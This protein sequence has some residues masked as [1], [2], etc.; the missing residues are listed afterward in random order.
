[1]SWD[2]LEGCALRRLPELPDE[3]VQCVVTSPPYWGLRDYG[4]DGQIGLEETPA[5]WLDRMVAVFHEVLRVLRADGTCWVNVG[6]SYATGTTSDRGPTHTGTHGYWENPQVNKRINGREYGLK[7]KDLV[8]IPW[9]L[10]F[11]LRADG[12]Y[13]RQDIIWAKP[14]P[15][16]ESA[17]DRCTK[18]HEY[19]FLLTKSGRYYYDFDAMQEPVTGNAHSRGNG[20]NP[21]AYKMPDGW[22]SSSGNGGHGSIH[23]QGREKGKTPQ[24]KQNES[25]SAAVTDPVASRNR[26]SVWTIPT[27]AFSEAHFATFPEALV[28][29]CIKAGSKEGDTIL[30]PFA[31][32]GTT[33]VVALRHGRNFIGIE[34]SP[35]YAAMAR[36]RITND[37]P[38]FNTVEV[39]A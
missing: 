14:N 27:Q 32:S 17:R 36:R 18:S 37:A 29:P 28:E 9:M 20:I 34:L 38:L 23:K 35:E 30:D 12:W 33:G 13:L 39:T 2:I 21:K 24:S 11:A 1:M 25:F 16:P 10:A 15:M 26:R 5:E 3:S 8:G 22:D 31:G 6:D 19:I 7:P 4:V